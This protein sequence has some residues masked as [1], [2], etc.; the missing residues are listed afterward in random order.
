MNKGTQIQRITPYLDNYVWQFDDP[1]KGLRG[2]AFIA[3]A[4]VMMEYMSRDIRN[5]KDGFNLIFSAHPFPTH[6]IVV[7][8]LKRS[9]VTGEKPIA[10]T[11]YLHRDTGHELWLCPALLC[12][13]KKP[14]QFIYA[15]AKPLSRSRV[16]SGMLQQKHKKMSFNFAIGCNPVSLKELAMVHALSKRA[17]ASKR[18]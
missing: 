3:G 6:Q 14:P 7:E 16:S 4:D 9:I 13:F 12:Y 2:E 10:G 15:E 8:Q 17:R 1:A 18:K 5:A 11:Y